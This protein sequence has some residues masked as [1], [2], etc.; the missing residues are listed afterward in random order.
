MLLRAAAASDTR[1]D[2]PSCAA[3]ILAHPRRDSLCGALFD[4]CADGARLGGVEYRELILSEIRFD[5]NAR[6]RPWAIKPGSPWET[7]RCCVGAFRQEN[8]QE[9]DCTGRKRCVLSDE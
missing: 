1:F 7:S 9:D 4:A 6:D 5:P 8:R 2:A 3:L